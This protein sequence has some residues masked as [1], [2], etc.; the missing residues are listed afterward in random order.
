[1]ESVKKARN[2]YFQ[3]SKLLAECKSEA[4]AYAACISQSQDSIKKGMCEEDFIKFR[5]C[6]TKNAAKLNTKI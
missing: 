6:L 5:N 1:M 2:R 4:A 3:F